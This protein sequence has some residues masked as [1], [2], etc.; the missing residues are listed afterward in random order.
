ME[1]HLALCVNVTFN[2]CVVAFDIVK[3][4]CVNC[5]RWISRL[6]FDDDRTLGRKA[7]FSHRV[8][9]EPSEFHLRHESLTERGIR[10]I[11]G[12]A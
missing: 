9:P 2:C 7:V 10:G 8:T 3:M 6:R 5:A 4:S 11:S 1:G 12:K